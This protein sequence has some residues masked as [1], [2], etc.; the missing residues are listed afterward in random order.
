MPFASRK[1]LD[2][3][4]IRVMV[5]NPVAAYDHLILA[6]P[7]RPLTLRLELDGE[8]LTEQSYDLETFASRDAGPFVAEHNI[9]PGT[10]L[11]RLAYVGD[12]ASQDVVLLQETKEL[13]PGDIWRTIYEPRSF[14]KNPK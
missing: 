8:L 6:D 11:I 10:H 7:E 4:I 1:A 12:Q 14:A 2:T 13:R 9:E 3:A 5:E